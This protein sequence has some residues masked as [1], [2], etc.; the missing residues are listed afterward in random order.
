MN[1]DQSAGVVLLN[2]TGNEL[3]KIGLINEA[4]NYYKQAIRCLTGSRSQIAM[5]IQERQ[6]CSSKLLHT[7][8]DPISLQQYDGNIEN[9][10]SWHQISAMGVM[11][12]IALVYSA[13]NKIAEARSLLDLVLRAAAIQ[14]PDIRDYNI[15]S[16]FLEEIELMNY[17]ERF[18]QVVV[19]TLHLL[20]RIMCVQSSQVSLECNQL[21]EDLDGGIMALVLAFKLGTSYLTQYHPVVACVCSTLGH[22]LMQAHRFE[23]AMLTFEHAWSI[24]ATVEVEVGKDFTSTA[25]AA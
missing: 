8:P 25:P 14:I 18:A 3:F 11:F 17:S 12:N 19:H 16:E 13:A 2:E 21:S 6:Q 9:F 22:V 15:F 1:P 7:N 23:E 10:D 24:A 4:S 5:T 20:G